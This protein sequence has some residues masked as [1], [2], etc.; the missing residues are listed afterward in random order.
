MP[1]VSVILTS[2][3]HAKYLCEAIDSVLRQTFADFELIIWDDASKDDSWSIIQGY[4]DPRIK[5]FRNDEQR[6]G[7]Y[8]INKSISEVAQGEYIAIHHSDDVWETDKLAK[9]VTF[10]NSNPDVGSVFTWASIINEHGAELDEEWFSRPNQSRWSWLHELFNEENHLNHPSVLLR[11]NC[12]EDVG[13][14]RYGLAQTGDAEMWSRLLLSFP[15]HV[16]QEKLTKHRLFSDRSNTSGLRPEVL[17]R[18]NN[19]WN[20]LRRNFLRLK[21]VAEVYEIFPELPATWKKSEGNVKFLLAMACLQ[22]NQAKSAWELGMSW[23]FELL[24]DAGARQEI[25]DIY[26]FSY[27]DFVLL[28][29]QYDVYSVNELNDLNG[30]IANCNSALAEREEQIVSLNQ[31]MADRD[32]RLAQIL[33]SK[34]WRLARRWGAVENY[35]HKIL[36]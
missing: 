20:H 9:Q 14:Y 24:N 35:V 28:T 26:G 5:A 21:D 8:G 27:N 25:Q 31:A 2:F 34:S 7:I 19:E 4:S 1:K 13:L 30:Q 3:N 33:N 16:I 36:R 32:E 15:I 10:L 6:R 29:S 22:V 23:L 17:V 18:L 12:Y 11:R